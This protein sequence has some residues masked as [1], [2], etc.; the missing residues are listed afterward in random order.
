MSVS[1]F[2][3]PV[4]GQMTTLNALLLVAPDINTRIDALEAA[5][6]GAQANRR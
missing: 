2:I 5:V 6:K 4:R 1:R 3:S